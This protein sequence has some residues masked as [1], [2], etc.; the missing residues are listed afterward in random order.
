V[1]V[2][3][4]LLGRRGSQ[5]LRL[6]AQL[7]QRGGGRRCAR[8]CR[9]LLACKRSVRGL[10]QARQLGSVLRRQLAALGIRCGRRL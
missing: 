10:A 4:A 7:L 9:L 1:R 6:A 5:A 3:G 8:L 2:R